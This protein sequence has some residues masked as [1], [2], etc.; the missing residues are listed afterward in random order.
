MKK[1]IF[2]LIKSFVLKI[3]R[4]FLQKFNSL[5]LLRELN[6]KI[7]KAYNRVKEGNFNIEGLE[8]FDI[9]RKTIGI[10]G[11]GNIGKAFAQI[12]SGFG[13]QILIYDP[14]V[15][16]IDIPKN[17][18]L[19][20]LE[21]LL[22]KSDIISLHCPLTNETKYIIDEK[23]LNII[24]PS[25]YV[26]NTSRGALVD[27]QAIIKAL[28]SKAIAGLAVDVYEYEKDIFFKDMSGEIIA[29]DIFERLLTFPNVLVTAHQAFLTKE[30]LNG[31][32]S[33]T[34]DNAS[35]LENTD[36]CENLVL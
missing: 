13:G 21:T 16:D 24:K 2:I 3:R 30:A 15:T 27:T 26:I 34:L 22:K 10:I 23:A 28:K 1:A 32:A 7:H 14:F 35:S 4:I 12:M 33:T 20:S 11:F 25:A 5:S 31:I 19:V 29:D 8:G 6:R 17:S 36:S 9:Y 18:K